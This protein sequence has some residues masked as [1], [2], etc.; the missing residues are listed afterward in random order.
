M[1]RLCGPLTASLSG[2]PVESALPSRQGRELF[3]LLVL[4]RRR[5]VAREELIDALWP[6][7]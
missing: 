6:G 7:A 5:A 4:E 2:R 3:A 1:I